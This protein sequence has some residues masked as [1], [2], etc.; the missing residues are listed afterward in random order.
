MHINKITSLASGEKMTI[1][2]G[3]PNNI[4]QFL[5]ERR[6]SSENTFGLILSYICCMNYFIEKIQSAGDGTLGYNTYY[7]RHFG[8]KKKCTHTY[9]HLVLLG[10]TTSSLFSI[11][12]YFCADCTSFLPCQS[13]H[14]VSSST[15]VCYSGACHGF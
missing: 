7:S 5:K 1:L 8:E 9:C 4:F 2:F 14:H 10:I 12:V 3:L 11:H 6:N 15:I 13:L